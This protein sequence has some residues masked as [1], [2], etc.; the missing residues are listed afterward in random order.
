[1][2]ITTNGLDIVCYFE[3]NYMETDKL[4]L[5]KSWESVKEAL[6][7]INVELT[8]DDLTYQPGQEDQLL[9][10]LE[11]KMKKSKTEIKALIESISANKGKAS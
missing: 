3:N 7:E 2:R 5:E 8:D 11:K 6:K 10:R 4:K 1:M 9:G